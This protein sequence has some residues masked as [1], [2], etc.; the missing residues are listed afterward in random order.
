MPP[1]LSGAE[2]GGPARR[3]MDTPHHLCTASSESITPV[4]FSGRE[5]SGRLFWGAALSRTGTF[6][7]GVPQYVIYSPARQRAKKPAAPDP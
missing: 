5:E 6:S 2:A 3:V 7:R 4:F 1:V